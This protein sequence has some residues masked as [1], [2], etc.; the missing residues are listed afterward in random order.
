MGKKGSRPQ[1][2]IFI[3]NG[4]ATHNQ[5]KLEEKAEGKDLPLVGDEKDR[6]RATGGEGENPIQ[7]RGLVRT[8]PR[9]EFYKARGEGER[10]YYLFN[11]KEE[12]GED[13]QK[14]GGGKEEE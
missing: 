6:W 8:S 3:N 14:M 4:E 13:I 5:D 9:E 2:K 1:G 11:Q 10:E 7:S 12:R